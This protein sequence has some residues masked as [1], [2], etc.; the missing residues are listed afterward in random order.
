MTVLMET[1]RLTRHFR[2]RRILGG[3]SV[4]RAVDGVSLRIAAGEIVA[5]VGE[6]GSGKSSLVRCLL[7]IDQPTGGTILFDGQPLTSL[8]GTTAVRGFHRQ[9][10]AV[11][12]DPFSS[13]D[14]RWPIGR[15]VREALD[16]LDIGSRGDRD[17]VVLETLREVGLPESMAD[18]RPALMSGGQH[19]RVAIAAALA[20]R[21]RLLIADE[22]VTA[23]DASV[24][25]QILNLLSDLR[26]RR[27]LAILLVSHDLAVVE[28]VSDR[29]A[30]MHRGRV[31]ETGR[32]EDVLGDAKHPYT[33]TLVEATR[34][35]RVQ[36]GT[37][38]APASGGNA[39]GCLFA[40]RCPQR[41]EICDRS[42]PEPHVLA[43]GGP[44]VACHLFGDPSSSGTGSREGSADAALET[45]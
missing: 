12:Q 36:S 44:E 43:P 19:Q 10:Q 2:S 39:G 6:S 8:R 13:L 29:V 9:V 18:R 20:G 42:R 45:R 22:P 4:T 30:V 14:P 28:H 11:F 37:V 5:V 17:R 15:T 26:Q 3:G 40:D 41:M 25:A 38:A 33:R 34:K 31:V 32:V 16:C 7:G 21:P 1:D 23:L 24:Q 35:H 27:D